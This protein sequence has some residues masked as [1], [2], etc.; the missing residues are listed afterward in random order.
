MERII[1]LAGVAIILGIAIFF[2]K[3][4][5][6][7]KTEVYIAHKEIDEISGEFNRINDER[8]K[9]GEENLK[10]KIAIKDLV[11]ENENLK[12]KADELAR[13][14]QARMAEEDRSRVVTISSPEAE[15][16]RRLKAQLETILSVK[17]Q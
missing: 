7:L 16:A 12:A 6:S 9:T 13:A 2:S 4:N 5:F 1:K 14:F 17:K 10:Q 8:A 11:S 15:E 3:S